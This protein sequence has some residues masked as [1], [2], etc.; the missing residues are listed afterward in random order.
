MNIAFVN[1]YDFFSNSA[2]H[3]FYLAN[4]L[5]SAGRWCCRRANIGHRIRDREQGV[6]RAKATTPVLEPASSRAT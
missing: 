4:A 2:I 1:Y 6:W 3:I 5:C